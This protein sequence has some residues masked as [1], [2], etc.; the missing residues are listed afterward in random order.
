MESEI[1]DPVT[2]DDI[3]SGLVSLLESDILSVNSSS[4]VTRLSGEARLSKRW[5]GSEFVAGMGVALLCFVGGVWRGDGVWA[6]FVEV[7]YSSSLILP[8]FCLPL[9]PTTARMI[10]TERQEFSRL[11]IGTYNKCTV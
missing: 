6:C 5:I 11:T 8:F 4:K 9:T 2:E 10:I 3:L 7:R 1:G